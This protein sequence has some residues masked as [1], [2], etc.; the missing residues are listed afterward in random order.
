MIWIKVTNPSSQNEAHDVKDDQPH[1]RHDLGVLQHTGPVD[2]HKKSYSSV[3]HSNKSLTHAPLLNSS[4]Y[5]LKH[6][7]L[8]SKLGLHPPGRLL[9]I[10][11][12]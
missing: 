10:E 12:S 9:S 4:S 1:P 8:V 6:G 11:S 5:F 3:E 7:C 2:K